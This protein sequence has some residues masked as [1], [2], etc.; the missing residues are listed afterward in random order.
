MPRVTTLGKG[1]AQS[2]PLPRLI[3]ASQ[4]HVWPHSERPRERQRS[5]TVTRLPSPLTMLFL[6]ASSSDLLLQRISKA[7]PSHPNSS[8]SERQYLSPLHPEA[9][10]LSVEESRVLSLSGNNAVPAQREARVGHHPPG[11]PWP[12]ASLGGLGHGLLSK[13]VQESPQPRLAHS[14]SLPGSS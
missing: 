8:V 1:A 5:P 4:Q 7:W 6:L 3:P 9:N 12:R 13:Q 14:C 10:P 2:S 11:L